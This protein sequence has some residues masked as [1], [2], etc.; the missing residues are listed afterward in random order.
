MPMR[1]HLLPL[2]VLPPSLLTIETWPAGAP[3]IYLLADDV[4]A[5]SVF[6]FSFQVTWIGIALPR[7]QPYCLISVVDT[8]SSAFSGDINML[9]VVQ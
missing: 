2:I 3:S 8:Y 6:S 4:L 7:I 1:G 5:S 9:T